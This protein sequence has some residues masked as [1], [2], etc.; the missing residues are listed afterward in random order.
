MLCWTHCSLGRICVGGSLDVRDQSSWT[1]SIGTIC[2]VELSHLMV[3][4]EGREEVFRVSLDA[5]PARLAALGTHTVAAS[6]QHRD[7]T[8]TMRLLLQAQTA[9]NA[10]LELAKAHLSARGRGASH[11]EV[12]QLERDLSLSS[13]TPLPTAQTALNADLVRAK[14][15]L[16]TRGRGASHPEVPQL[17]R[18]LSLFSATPLP[19]GSGA[20]RAPIAVLPHLGVERAETSRSPQ[21]APSA[22]RA[23]R[24]PELRASE[25]TDAPI[26]VTLVPAPRSPTGEREVILPGGESSPS[27]RAFMKRIERELEKPPARKTSNAPRRAG[28][29]RGSVALP[30]RAAQ[31]HTSPS[32]S[33]APSRASSPSR[34]R[35]VIERTVSRRA[36]RANKPSG[37]RD[38]STTSK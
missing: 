28:G 16:A 27:H 21:R 31:W 22:W 29:G 1:W 12:L 26:I 25:A 23:H 17:E 13:A 9:L 33:R 10:D 2:K 15:H 7:Q 6:A 5:R 3:R 32:T 34:T 8:A 38:R 36:L 14:A 19:M 37:I 4:C 24:S 18:D 35:S 30:T 11:L 20:S